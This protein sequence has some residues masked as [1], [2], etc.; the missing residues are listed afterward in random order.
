M[1]IGAEDRK[2][3]IAASTLGVFALGFMIYNF[4]GSSGPENTVAPSAPVTFRQST[5][6]PVATHSGKASLDPTLHPEG[7]LLS[8][9]LLYS[10]KGRNIFSLNSA[11]V[12]KIEIPKPIAPVRTTPQPVQTVVNTGPP[13]PPPIDLKFFGTATREGGSRQA[14]FLKGDDVFI[15]SEGDIVSRRYKVG[16]IASN[17]VEVTDLTNNNRQR[18]PL[19]TQ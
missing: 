14:F 4:A 15:A 7:M 3:L 13:L 1:K 2:K 12:Q 6:S 16:P 9:A 11:P 8:E 18:L 17:S 10:G 5:P 19:A